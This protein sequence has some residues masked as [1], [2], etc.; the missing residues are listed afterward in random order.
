M[1]DRFRHII[2]SCLCIACL[3]CTKPAYYEKFQTIDNQW[4]HN[5]EYYFTYQIEDSLASYTMSL[6]VRNNN[7]YPYQNVWFFCVEE[8]PGGSVLRD[9]IECILADDFG[10][11]YGSGISIYHLS[12]PIRTGYTFP[13]TGQYTFTIRQGMRDD[14]LKGIEQ[15]GVRVEKITN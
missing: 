12:V 6:E 3:S 14:R 5:K 7:F 15:I 13:H 11:W 10:K 9:T 4:D 2:L 8:Q 1:S